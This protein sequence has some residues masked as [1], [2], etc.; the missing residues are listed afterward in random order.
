[1][2]WKP[3]PRGLVITSM[4]F[5]IVVAGAAHAN[6]DQSQGSPYADDHGMISFVGSTATDAPLPA[7]ESDWNVSDV[8]ERCVITESAAPNK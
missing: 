8:A 2:E 1:M 7:W 5:N 4:V 6:Q 3:T